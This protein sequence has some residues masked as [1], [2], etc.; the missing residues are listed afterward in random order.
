AA[1]WINRVTWLNPLQLN[2]IFIQQD[3]RIAHPVFYGFLLLNVIRWITQAIYRTAIVGLQYTIRKGT[4]NGKR[5][6][7][8]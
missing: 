1:M 3:E 8:S 7:A 2:K 5:T 6:F 4:I